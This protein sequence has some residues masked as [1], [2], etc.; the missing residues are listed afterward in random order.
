MSSSLDFPCQFE[1]ERDITILASFV[2][3]AKQYDHRFA[4]MD[5]IHPVAGSIVDPHL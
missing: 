4:A 2:S 5:E 3:A 1:G